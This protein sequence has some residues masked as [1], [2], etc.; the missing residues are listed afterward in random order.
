MSESVVPL[1]DRFP[2]EVDE[3]WDRIADIQQNCQ[4]NFRLCYFF[5]RGNHQTCAAH[6]TII[7]FQFG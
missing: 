3:M 4:H 2:N 6:P 7:Q 5:K 1:K